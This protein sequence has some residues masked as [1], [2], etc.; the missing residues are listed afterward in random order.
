M[1]PQIE[2]V[3]ALVASAT[4]KPAYTVSVPAS[5]SY[6]YLIVA[7]AIGTADEA[8]LEGA[9]GLDLTVTVRAVAA[10][11]D[12]ALILADVARAA[13]GQTRAVDLSVAGHRAEIRWVRHEADYLDRDVTLPATG[14]HP[15]LSVDSYRLVSAPA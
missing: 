7:P 12:A 3:R 1:R 8:T 6:P 9:T 2:A 13:L 4:A 5:P 10:T 14:T 11:P 15:A